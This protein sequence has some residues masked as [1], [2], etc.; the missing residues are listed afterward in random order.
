MRFAKVVVLWSAMM[1]LAPAASADSSWYLSDLDASS[2]VTALRRTGITQAFFSFT[3]AES[4]FS[5]DLDTSDCSRI[6]VLT[7]RSSSSAGEVNIWSPAELDSTAKQRLYSD[8][9]AV[10]LDGVTYN[11]V[12][13]TTWGPVPAVRVEIAAAAVGSE[14][15]SVRIT[16]GR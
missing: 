12:G 4:G 1:L 13:F 5:A 16:C 11:R 3:G 14:T 9:G 8:A 7:W 2:T 15:F 6:S 10:T